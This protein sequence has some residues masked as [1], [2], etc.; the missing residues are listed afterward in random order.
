[1]KKE[2]FKEAEKYFKLA[3]NTFQKLFP[4]GHA[5]NAEINHLLGELYLKM[6]DPKRAEPVFREAMETRAKF[7]S[8]GD[9]RIADS[10]IKLGISMAGRGEY[11]ESKELL[12]TGIEM[13]NE[14]DREMTHLRTLAEETLARL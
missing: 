4:D 11:I 9:T 10:M 1:M 2:E 7:F 5:D 14:S 8:E 13:I 6:N 3:L 12:L